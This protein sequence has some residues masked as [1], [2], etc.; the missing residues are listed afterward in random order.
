MPCNCDES[1]K[2]KYHGQIVLY[3]SMVV[4]LPSG[5]ALPQIVAP[6]VVCVNCGHSEFQID[7]ST[8]PATLRKVPTPQSY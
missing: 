8:A 4:G 6:V 1:F 2:R 5:A 3:S 7:M